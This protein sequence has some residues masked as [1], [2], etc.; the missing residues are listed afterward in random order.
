MMDVLCCVAAFVFVESEDGVNPPCGQRQDDGV[1]ARSR[2]GRAR[3]V[4]RD[5]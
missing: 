1:D 2:A 4:G 5:R 3:V